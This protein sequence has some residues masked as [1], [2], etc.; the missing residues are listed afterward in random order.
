MSVTVGQQ[1][2]F[3][4]RNCR[5][6]NELNHKKLYEKRVP[7][8]SYSEY[9]EEISIKKGKRQ[10]LS[11]TRKNCNSHDIKTELDNWQNTFKNINWL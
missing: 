9:K 10:E 8:L 7:E 1:L 6:K 2:S 11:T 3:K 4:A 5:I